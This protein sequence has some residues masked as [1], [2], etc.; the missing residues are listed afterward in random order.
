MK[1]SQKFKVSIVVL[2]AVVMLLSAVACGK[3]DKAEG[4]PAPAPAEQAQT[5]QAA[6]SPVNYPDSAYAANLKASDY[7][8]PAEY[9]GI[10]VEAKLVKATAEE[11][12]N[13]IEQV[14]EAQAE[15]V[16][17]NGRD[18]VQVGDTVNIDYKG[19]KDGV[20]FD[21]GTAEGFDLKIGSGRFIDGFED[22]LVG[23]KKGE[24]VKLDLT[25]PE[26]YMNE[27]LAGQAVVFEVKINKISE[28]KKAE[29]T[30][31]FAAGLGITDEDGNSVDT[32][33]KLK[34]YVEKFLNDQHETNYK[35]SMQ[36]QIMNYLMENSTFA[37]EL[38]ADMSARLNDTLTGF[39]S[40]Y[41]SMY[42]M[43]MADFILSFFG[44]EDAE[45][46]LKDSVD[47]YVKQQLVMQAIAETESIKLEEEE[48]EEK[49]KEFA[50]GYGMSVEDYRS[51]VDEKAMFEDLLSQKV[52]DFL[53]ENAKI[54]EPAEPAE[55]AE[56]AEQAETAEPAK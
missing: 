1:K 42:G 15:L 16:E 56:S 18:T 44:E 52:M 27:D 45:Q 7:V 41:A 21:G 48:L 43:E 32:V 11:I 53:I 24:T 25:F 10:A 6:A 34:A 40:S 2:T 17:V 55:Q 12:M 30:D 35:T 36:N 49:V 5:E 22:G 38:P 28:D 13:E 54:S 8:T 51:S 37:E 39:Y 14:L 46:F 3:K 20:A 26:Q 50:E 4:T 31:D 29:L 9:K 33:D 23:C 47:D 19:T